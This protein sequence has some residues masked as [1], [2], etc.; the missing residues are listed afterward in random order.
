M[1]RGASLDTVP[2]ALVG[3][4][5]D[6]GNRLSQ[7]FWLSRARGGMAD[8]PDLG[9]GPERVRGS[10][11]LVR[12]SM[13]QPVQTTLHTGKFLALIK[14]GHWEFRSLKQWSGWR[15]KQKPGS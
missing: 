12:T 14:E 6:C 10:S 3:P 9:S 7:A 4:Q 8:A 2:G 13:K 5:P 11:P 1:E 15:P